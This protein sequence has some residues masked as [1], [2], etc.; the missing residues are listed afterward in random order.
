M[1]TGDW[2]LGIGDWGLGI[3]DWAE[4]LKI[5]KF[6]SPCSLPPAP[7]PPLP[8]APLASSAPC[9]TG[10]SRRPLCLCFHVVYSLLV[11]AIPYTPKPLYPYTPISCRLFAV[12]A[13]DR[14]RE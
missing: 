9:L 1:G 5:Q 3:G 2:G 10:T 14:S 12:G 11:L 7:L 13:G 8:P 4:K 6:F